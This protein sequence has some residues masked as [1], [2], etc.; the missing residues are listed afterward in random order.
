MDLKLNKWTN[1]KN[2]LANLTKQKYFNCPNQMTYHNL[3]SPIEL[4]SNPLAHGCLL[5]L[6]LKF[7]I[8][9]EKPKRDVS[10]NNFEQFNRGV[11]LRYTFTGKES[12][13][14]NDKKIYVKSNW[15]PDPVINETEQILA[16]F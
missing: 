15:I 13:A 1:A 2:V 8:Q 4:Q 5:G 16:T 11:R 12:T 10:D 6:G 9:E 14:N 7:C 3:H